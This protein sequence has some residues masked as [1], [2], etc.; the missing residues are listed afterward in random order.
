M[1]EM[2]PV[3]YLFGV[4]RLCRH[5]A[6]DVVLSAQRP[7]QL[8]ALLACRNEWVPRAELAEWLWPE[9][10]PAAAR[11]NLRKV[12]LLAQSII[13]TGGP[14]IEQRAELLL[15]TPDSDLRR[16]EAACV[17]QRAA[18]AVAWYRPLLL[19]GLDRGL[20]PAAQDWLAFERL[21]LAT[22]WRT[23]ALR[24]LQELDDA[25]A[26][27]VELAERLLGADP[28]DENALAALVQA[29][30]RSGEA[31]MAWRLLR[32][33]RQRLTE[34]LGTEPS[35][36]MRALADR[37]RSQGTS[38]L[39]RP[40]AAGPDAN[41]SHERGFIGRRLELGQLR[42]W[43]LREK[44]RVICV[45][46]PGGI[47][48]TSL[49]RAL[50]DSLFGEYDARA[51]WVSLT[52]LGEA[53]QLPLRIA[54]AMGLKPPDRAEA[55]P[56]RRIERG[57]GVQAA[58]LVLD[59]G[60]Q[61]ARLVDSVVALQQACPGLQVVVTSRSRLHTDDEWLLPLDGLPLP[62]ADER[63]PDVLRANDA[64]IL[65][66]ARARAAFSGFVLGRQ[67]ADVVSFVRAVEGLPLAIELGAALTRL[68]PVDQ[69]L[70]EL[71][72]SLDVMPA[73]DE[74]SMGRPER[75]LRATFDAS[76][77]LLSVTERRALAAVALLP[78]D[79][80]RT[81]AS[82]VATVPMPLLS[83][84]VDKSLVRADGSGRF[85][86][87]PLLKRWAAAKVPDSSFRLE[88]SARHAA[89]VGHQIAAIARANADALTSCLAEVGRDMPHVRAAWQRALDIRQ[90]EFVE[91]VTPVLWQFF[92]ICGPLSDGMALFGEAADVFASM[93]EPAAQRAVMLT[94]RAQAALQVR[95]SRFAEGEATARRAF[96][97][98]RRLG[99]PRTGVASLTTIGLSL[100]ARGM[101]ARARPIFAQ[102]VQRN[103]SLRD[104]ARLR[105]AL[106]NLAIV[107][108]ALGHHEAARA[109]YRE[110]IEH[111]RR[112][113]ETGALVVYLNNLGDAHRGEGDWPAARVAYEEALALCERD[114]IRTR[115][116]T[117]L[118][119]IGITCHAMGDVSGAARWIERA[120]AELR[121]T[122]DRSIEVSTLLARASLRIDETDLRGARADLRAA[123]T[124]AREL[125]SADLQIRAAIVHGE[126]LMAQSH[127]EGARRWL[128]WALG[129]PE[130]YAVERTT[131][132]RRLQRRGIEASF[133]DVT[134][135]DAGT[136]LHSQEQAMTLLA[137]E[138]D[139]PP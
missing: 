38:S 81:L 112:A 1:A 94:L 31:A 44:R 29:R 133:I 127:I 91:Q 60:E 85:S 41:A 46:G 24:R 65:F 45:T 123:M 76:W 118:V 90:P 64:I 86:M 16:F 47:G 111:S 109:I 129:Q 12:L 23:A 77:R 42:D 128:V 50:L 33:H 139:S 5:A 117:K 28:Y 27:V 105:I 49:A 20:A 73:A 56:W 39:P 114:G 83:T 9:R 70:A 26:D 131:A 52:A 54:Q 119:N 51:W 13:G 92:E 66:E 88:S 75:S 82:Q 11:S 37:A 99:D 136:P 72:A 36:A 57:L 115:L 30:L 25:P 21:R 61:F 138:I 79:F 126:L 48:K 58:L 43:L 125:D 134:V 132:L 71:V 2:A 93:P 87:H 3:L 62:D 121:A 53:G 32:A 34:E 68:L 6:A 116:G 113:G 10:A 120:L 59:N 18:E 67:V 107:H 106:G 63:D 130:L 8:L 89:Y 98:A 4:P 22:A 135:G 15:W 74:A 110:V 80:D 84:L 35:P 95:A 17:G 104:E 97:L 7:H 108:Q 78:G 122:G 137:Q 40:V 124:A 103:R 102:I 14:P 96:Q 19:N 100:F 69:I 101:Y 55:E